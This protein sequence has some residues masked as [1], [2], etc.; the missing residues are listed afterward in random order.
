MSAGREKIKLQEGD[1][2]I[3]ITK[4]TDKGTY[5]IVQLD[6][7]AVLQHIKEFDARINQLNTQIENELSPQR[8]AFIAKTLKESGAIGLSNDYLDFDDAMKT[9]ID[10]RGGATVR[11]PYVNYALV[12]PDHTL[13]KFFNSHANAKNQENSPGM[14]LEKT[15]SPKQKAAFVE[16]V[17]RHEEGH[18]TRTGPEIFTPETIEF[19][20]K[21]YKTLKLDAK[22]IGLGEAGADFYA[23][24][25]LLKNNP[26]ARS[27]MEIVGDA[28]T[29]K[30][31]RNDMNF[32]RTS[33]MQYH[34]GNFFAIST[35]LE[36]SPDAIE[37]MSE[38]DI[39]KIASE[40]FDS[41]RERTTRVETEV[42]NDIYK[43]M[44]IL[45]RETG[46]TPSLK[47]AVDSLR[48]KDVYST[49]P[50]KISGEDNAIKFLTLENM[51][52]ALD[53]LEQKGIELSGDVFKPPA[54]QSPPNPSG[55][56]PL[57]P[58]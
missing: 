37:K 14:Q 1:A 8:D 43:E 40:Q 21:E 36:L 29:I 12:D 55:V 46:R 27:V 48:S 11:T 51:K 34:F 24:V 57:V 54:P 32:G 2:E 5:F 38:E 3:G 9:L 13:S 10:L 42:K 47:E 44:E 58:G 35:A 50:G 18:S 31:L 26:E 41:L 19:D 39:V 17:E 15:L 4:I 16:Y 56:K 23:A 53:R 45:S 33:L 30:F 7:K 20:G 22:N 49:A 25:M 28:Q 6:R 52:A